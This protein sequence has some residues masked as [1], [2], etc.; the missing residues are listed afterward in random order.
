MAFFV[1]TPDGQGGH[2]SL[3]EK[4]GEAGRQWARDF[5]RFEDMACVFGPSLPSLFLSLSK[6]GVAWLTL[7]LPRRR[8]YMYRLSLEYVRILHH[9]EGDVDYVEMPSFDL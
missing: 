6:M 4:I 3:A 8:A 7:R 9:D 1:G 2:D 5:W